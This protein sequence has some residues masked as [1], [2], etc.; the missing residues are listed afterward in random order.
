MPNVTPILNPTLIWLGVRAMSSYPESNFEPFRKRGTSP[1]VA[2]TLNLTLVLGVGGEGGK[3]LNVSLTLNM[4]FKI[5]RY[6]AHCHFDPKSNFDFVGGGRRGIHRC[7][8][9]GK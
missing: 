4:T 8:V 7:K 9:C 3:S 2:P 1:N 6:I 5:G